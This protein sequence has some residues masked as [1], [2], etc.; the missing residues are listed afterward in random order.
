MPAK[1]KKG[2]GKK[3]DDDFWENAGEDVAP[4][5]LAAS[6]AQVSDGEDPPVQSKG[7]GGFA[8]LG[9]DGG[10]GGE[11]EEDFGGLMS[12]IKA[13]AK[14]KKDKKKSRKGAEPS[15]S[16]E[17]GRP[18]GEASDGEAAAAKGDI[19]AP[20]AP[21]QVTAEDL[22]NEE[23]G[24][25]EEK[26]GKKGKKGKKGKTTEKL[27]TE[28]PKPESPKSLPPPAAEPPKD[29]EEDAPEGTVLS[30]KEKERMKKEKEK[31]KKKAQAA[32]KKTTASEGLETPASVE[33][34]LPQPQ[35]ET[36]VADKE[37]A[38]EDADEGRG[39]GSKDK[40]KKKKK[41]AKKEEIPPPAAKKPTGALA[42]LK[43]AMEQKRLLEE[44]TKRREEE[45][46]RRIEEEERKAEEEERLKEEAKQ[47][48]KEKEKA[49]REVLK[50]EGR[51]LTK[52]QKEEKAA[53]E[54]RRKA[55][56]ESG[57]KIEGLQQ[58]VR[59][60]APKKVVY[61][62]RK[63]R[64]PAVA[65]TKESSALLA[66]EV[67]VEPT[68]APREEAASPKGDWEA[69]GD[70][71]DTA[72]DRTEDVKDSWDASSGDETSEPLKPNKK[73]IELGAPEKN[74]T[75]SNAK[76]TDKTGQALKPAAP[77]PSAAVQAAANQ[78]SEEDSDG[79]DESDDS[80]E[81]DS[82]ESDSEGMTATQR[83]AAQR[84]AE[85]A[86]RRVKRHEEALAQRSKD[87]LRSPICCILGHVD[88]GK[89]KLLDKIRQTNVQEGEAGGITQ[90]IG[91]TYFP[92]DAIKTKTAV[93]NTDGAFDY[94]IPG[95]LIIDTP[96]HESF[97]NL[98]SRGSSLCNIAI[99]V[100]DIMHGLEPQTLESLRL[101]RDRK[102]PFIVALNK[103]DR[104]YGWEATP[105]NS[106]K[107]SLEKQQSS[108]KREFEHRLEQTK[109]AF[110]EQG[111]N[112]ELYYENKNV[113]RNVS[114][115][116]TSA[117]TGEGV[118]DMI[119]LLVKL[120]QERMSD[121][122]MYLS[123]L[124]CTVLEVKVI[125]GL[126]TTID[127]VL[128]NG[129]LREGDR[130]VVCGLNGPIVTN[131]RALLTPQPLR[132]LR[133]KS[134][135]VHHKEVKAALG[136]KLTA[137]DLEKAIAG[138]RLLVVGPDDDED[139]LRD[140]VMSDLT[141]LLNTIDKSGHGVCV[142]ASTLGSLEALLDFLKV[143]KIPVSG[144]NIGP[145]HKKDIMRS[146]TMLEKAKELACILCFDV[147]VDKEAE[148]LAEELGIRLFKADIIYHLFDAFTAY[149]AEIT[150][151]KR[152]DAAPQAVWPCRL[153]IIAAFC[154]RDP[155][156]LG[157]DILDGTLRVGTPICVVKTDPTTSKRETIRLG[158]ITSLEINHKS[159]DIVKKSQA[160]GGVAVKIEH[161]VYE[162]A[163]MFGRHFDDKDELLSQITRQSIDVL[164]ASFKADV[165][166][167]EWLLLKGLKQ[168]LGIP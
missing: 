7:F 158:K 59:V 48:R 126:G 104:M 38:D 61:G 85:A 99:L 109:L 102:T 54:I 80:S 64:G 39:G 3:K 101:L 75:P 89:T 9:M 81:N 110:A 10:A 143:S 130:I 25:V 68:E 26:G 36:T 4:N 106:F 147:T 151:A 117:I 35:I 33:P 127:V 66:E 95:L 123:E 135:Y 45:E 155:I 105:N 42:A 6:S 152:K 92:V 159:M 157:V 63:K 132:E 91:A 153:K 113:A 103:I 12:T 62:N 100:V 14:N 71:E 21:V 1:G 141:S 144:I 88:T 112:A 128:S 55:L 34:S 79:S 142:Q 160:G 111:L 24:P 86:E 138:S 73:V 156:I 166:N 52:K 150:E 17:D 60:A 76:S 30:K 29:D 47:R 49:K 149:N 5:T 165:S 20:K 148:K 56:L 115:V 50:K 124:E 125:E 137:P 44:E 27:D 15:V 139:D 32:A 65:A 154:K 98:R 43:A 13:A 108:V 96:G 162:S 163:K 93:M 131:V 67:I 18:P 145:V 119:M 84:K 78:S 97:T 87:D 164:K 16:F 122:L 70:E 116:P 118:P 57:V 40:K 146:A 2:K 136:V 90:Q 129:I 82:S 140:E 114:L 107:A 28:E 46:R 72:E 69:G 23:W 134:A 31:A 22:A 11:E 19:S 53:A 51:L 168:R 37:E 133:I 83:Q 77:A 94:K 120:T 58:T 74:A 41:T 161:A 121:R 167:E 8:A